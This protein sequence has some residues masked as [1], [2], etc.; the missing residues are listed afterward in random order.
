MD[1]RCSLRPVLDNPELADLW[2]Q[3]Q[4][5]VSGG[6]RGDAR[7]DLKV[8]VGATGAAASALQGGGDGSAFR[9]HGING[10]GAERDARVVPRGEGSKT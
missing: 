3:T 8:R 7:H 4:R 5:N 10:R 2:A 9:E 1:A 6:V